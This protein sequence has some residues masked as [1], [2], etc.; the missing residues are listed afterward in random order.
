MKNLKAKTKTTVGVIAMGLISA[1]AMVST[2]SASQFKLSETIEGHEI[3]ALFSGSQDITNANLITDITDF[4]I[5][6]VSGSSFNYNSASYT[7]VSLISSLQQNARVSYDG[8]DNYFNII[9]QS[10]DG[11]TYGQFSSYFDSYFGKS[12]TNFN[13]SKETY[14][15]DGMPDQT[16]LLY[17]YSFPTGI[18][19][20]SVSSVPL[21]PAALMFASGLLGFGAFR[22]KK[23]QA[24]HLHNTLT[25]N[26]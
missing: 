9:I 22:K 21:P 6:H 12:S 14:D 4:H 11:L 20:Y 8:S 23:N 18:T 10:S 24:Q 26:A 1:T 5:S 13:L 2:A 17:F 16:Q 25:A 19:N 3:T 15:S 7:D